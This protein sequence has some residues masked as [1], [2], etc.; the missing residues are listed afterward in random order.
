[1]TTTTTKE[2]QIALLAP[3]TVEGGEHPG[4]EAQA[5]DNT[6]KRVVLTGPAECV[7]AAVALVNGTLDLDAK[8]GS[9][10]WRRRSDE[11]ERQANAAEDRATKA[12]KALKEARVAAFNAGALENKDAK[13]VAVVVDD[14]AVAELAAGRPAT[15]PKAKADALEAARSPLGVVVSPAAALAARDAVNA[16]NTG[17]AAPVTGYPPEGNEPPEG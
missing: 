11:M 1:M 5:F 12:E 10:F 8:A 6:G 14:A 15:L 3:W 2:Q 17:P 7:R 16:K 9:L 13:P 4:S